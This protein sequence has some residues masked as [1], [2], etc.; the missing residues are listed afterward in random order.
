MEKTKDTKSK[1]RN[2]SNHVTKRIPVIS[3]VSFAL[4]MMAFA[5]AFSLNRDIIILGT[6]TPG[7]GFPVYGAVF[8]E[9]VNQMDPSLEVQTRNTKGSTENVPLL[10]AGELDIALVQGEVV[11][12]AFLDVSRQPADLKIITA[13][14]STAGLFVVRGNSSYRSIRDL[15]GQPVVFG[16]RGS[17]LVLLARYVLEGIGLD[18]DRDFKAIYVDRAGDGPGMLEDGRAA[19]LWGGGIGWP[20][21]VTVSKAK[22]GARFIA[23]AAIEI[24]LILAKYP[25]L[26]RLTIPAG[27]YPGQDSPIQSVGSWSFVLARTTLSDDI[28]YRLARALHRSESMMEKRLPQA[29]ETTMINTINAAPRQDLIHSGVLRYLREIGLVK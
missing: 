17:G 16:A 14:Y 7:G 21:F 3:L 4:A 29:R 2:L 13:M 28:T 9:A 22:S 26:K 10:E 25:F 12:A 11:Q 1:D 5:I 18:I 27:S 24:N 23:P 15:I 20:G 6:A 19:A 8:A